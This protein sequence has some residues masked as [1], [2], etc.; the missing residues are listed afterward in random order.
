MLGTVNYMAPEQIDDAKNAGPK[1]DVY[2]LGAT[3]YHCLTGE[4]PISGDNLVTVLQRLRETLPVAPRVIC[5]G[6]NADLELI[7]LRCI[8]KNPQ[9]RYESAAHLAADLHRYLSGEPVQKASLSWW[10]SLSRQIRR[11]EL[12]LEMPSATAAVWIATLTL[13]FHTTVFFVIYLNLSNIFLWLV[14]AIWFIGTNLVNY[15][16][17]WSQF[18]QLTPM[19]RQ[20]GIIQL[21][22]HI[23][24]VCLYL[25]NGPLTLT[26]SSQQ[27][28]AIY[29]P[30]T[31]IVAVAFAA[32]VNYFGRMLLPAFL[33]FPLSILIAY[34]PPL[35]GPLLLGFVGS[36]IAAW[37]SIK[38]LNARK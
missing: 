8:Q 7:C 36:A 4:A 17:H 22:V 19:E 25:A 21:A 33:F 35:C 28:L 27:F 1:T 6:V 20:S 34:M 32:H 37:C 38:L 5:P 11:D 24:F 31:L 23:S 15:I 30:F 3:L 12:S 16:Y 10:H 2:G 13:V 29:P 9:D 14:L 26:E 18:W